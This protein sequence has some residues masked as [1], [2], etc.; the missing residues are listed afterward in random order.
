[1]LE[2]KKISKVY[3][4]NGLKSKALN[5][6]S[7][8]FRESEFASILG[9]SGSGKTTFLNI[10]GGLD[11]Y[12]S[13]D[14]IINEIST[15][16]FKDSDWDSYRNHRI[17][18][19]F[20]SYN[21]ISHQTILKNV[22]LALTLS[23]ILK[24]EANNRA[25]EALKE[26]GLG[27][28][29][30]KR[31]NQLSGGQMQR[32]AIAR[33]LVNNPDILLADEP[34]GALD[35][36]TSVQIMEILK[37]VAEKKLV[38]MVTHNPEL[39]EQYSTRIITLKDGKI[40]DDTN[41]YDGKIDTRDREKEKEKTKKTKM[42]FL[43]S[44]GL[45][46]NNLMTKKARTILV[47]IAGSI[48]IIGIALVLALS[49]GFQR[50]VDS[51]EEDTLTSYPLTIMQE[52]TDLTSVLLSTVNQNAEEKEE[53]IVKE[54]QI[55]T[56]TLSSLSI[57]DLESF[58]KYLDENPE[59]Y[60][61]DVNNIRYNYSIDPLIYSKNQD[62]KFLKLNPT[63]LFS[64]LMGGSSTLLSSYS[65]LTSIY[66]QLPSTDK[67]ELEENYELVA[68]RF[69]ENYDEMILNLK[70]KNIIS[71]L[72]VYSLGFRDID[73]LKAMITK[74]M[75]GEAVDE[76]DDPLKLTYDDIMN[77][78]LKLIM[79]SDLYRYNAEYN[80]YEDMSGN[81]EY[82]NNLYKNATTLK[83]VGI[84]TSKDDSGLLS[85]SSMA[86]I[87]Y[88]EELID[89][90][91]NYSKEKDIVKK[92]LD[93]T[94]I[95]V[96]SG[97]RFD[98]ESKSLGLD[99]K[100]FVTIDENKLKNAFNVDVDKNEIQSKVTAY[101]AEIQSNL[102]I[103]ITP[104]KNDFDAVLNDLLDDFS[105]NLPAEFTENDIN[106]LVEKYLSTYN[107]STKIASL[108]ET[109]VIPT[110]AFKEVFSGLLK[111]Y[112]KIYV[113]IR[114]Q[115]AEIITDIIKENPEILE[116]LDKY[117]ILSDSEQIVKFME[118][119]N[120]NEELAQTVE[121]IKEAIEKYIEE[122]P[123]LKEYA[124][125]IEQ[126]KD[127]N[128]PEIVKKTFKEAIATQGIEDQMAS[129]M[130]E[131]KLQKTVLSEVGNLTSYLTNSFASAFNVDP[132][133]ISSAFQLNV[134]EEEIS[135][136]VTAMMSK[137]ESTQTSN[138]IALGYQDKAKPT[139]IYVYFATFE[140]KENFMKLIDEYNEGVEEEKQIKY[141]DTTGI[142]MSSV[143][144]IV[145]AVT[146]VLIGFV[147]ISLVVSSI[148]IGVITY[149][150]VYERTKE[151]GILRAIGASKHNITNIFNSETF[152]IGLLSGI[153]AM[154][155]S[156]LLIPIINAVIF[157]FT[158]LAALSAYL[159]MDNTIILVILS[160]ILTLIGGF[161]P[162][163]SASKK[164][165][166]EALR[167]E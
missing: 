17:G 156:Y 72:L 122:N 161:I 116:A 134:T 41:P 15:K 84:T 14:L 2:I 73:E 25:K 158:G 113:S 115:N 139:S 103:D 22:S 136:I 61:K 143:K 119:L 59:K 107:S 144:T 125:K 58:K 69:P 101:I 21:L 140:G 39:A 66:S 12:T 13:G 26:V 154:I 88:S 3:S 62:N 35:S 7:V 44:F 52:T 91:I 49:N 123:E 79:P 141:S 100:N 131:A 126:E 32:V 99:F 132:E 33:A 53:G 40:T 97:K 112:L 80:I 152:I 153:L 157:H 147:S 34:T 51:V 19:V 50:Y 46:F 93:T 92:Q 149:I 47:S 111:T 77:V 106:S 159:S 56:D 164:D 31:P 128:L 90:I 10:I 70:D 108:S 37:K 75:S 27:E 146:Y 98:E 45:S 145:D 124:D 142:L 96:I 4:T 9:P 87:F 20:Q 29:I 118:Y 11:D 60:E 68:G 121:G 129:V 57:N 42:S 102:K 55:I 137:T 63:N 110:S 64:S 8:N 133:S 151:I 85:T 89:H 38:I 30:N 5:K 65:T 105:A 135:R 165:P 82:M 86:G 167:T 6:V 166:V 67:S 48:G 148:M 117:G 109:Y 76:V 83:I 114:D 18:F 155:I 24:K 54:N 162:A 163:K 1:M 81:D 94:E 74:I 130:T 36:E 138:L 16:K 71:E 104:A 78:E 28:H 160:V 120:N 150:S 23:G 43:T 127:K 95:D